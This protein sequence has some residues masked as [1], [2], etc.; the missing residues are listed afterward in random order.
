M[1]RADSIIPEGIVADLKRLGFKYT[2]NPQYEITKLA[3]RVQVRTDKNLAPKKEIEKYAEAMHYSKFP[4][5]ILTEDNC[6]VEGN[7]RVEAYKHN[8]VPV[9]WAI[10]L[11]ARNDDPDPVVKARLHGLAV[12]INNQNGRSHDDA[13]NRDAVKIAA[14]AGWTTEHIAQT[15]KVSVKTAAEISREVM[16]ETKLKALDVPLNGGLTRKQLATLGSD[17]VIDI[18]NEPYK[19]LTSLSRDAGLG[20]TEIRSLAKDIKAAGSDDAAI[21]LISDKRSEMSD[22]LA[23]FHLTGT[24]KPKPPSLLRQHLG[25][26]LK[27][28]GTP[29]ALVEFG[30]D[31]KESHLDVVRR[32][33]TVLQAVLTAQESV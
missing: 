8:K 7:T 30:P 19:A 11:D 2:E 10:I 26:V 20:V 33:V 3:G 32:S 13:E 1:S 27:Y 18:N 17:K 22:R 29:G 5:V 14:E 24:S 6:I 16:A 21:Q 31:Y 4:P 12:S 9:M 28:E 25:F 23:E 15:L